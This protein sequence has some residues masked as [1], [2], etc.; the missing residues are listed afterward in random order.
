MKKIL[1]IFIFVIFNFSSLASTIK[2][3][4]ETIINNDFKWFLT[5]P[6]ALVG[7]FDDIFKSSIFVCLSFL[8]FWT[9]VV[10][11]LT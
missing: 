7:L 3:E 6:L 2:N 8:Y 4:F 1:I 11:I 5:I 10:S 9:C